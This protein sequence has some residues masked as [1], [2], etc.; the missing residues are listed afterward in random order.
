MPSLLIISITL[1]SNDSAY[2]D[3]LDL[4]VGYMYASISF[5]VSL[6]LSNAMYALA[7][8]HQYMYCAF[9]RSYDTLL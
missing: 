1:Y 7:S 9:K 6:Y 3:R 5:P 8:L 4:G 2:V